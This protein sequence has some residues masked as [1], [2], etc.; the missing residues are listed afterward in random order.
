[1]FIFIFLGLCNQTCQTLFIF[2]VVIF[3]TSELVTFVAE[4]TQWKI[5]PYYQNI[6]ESVS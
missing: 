5:S 6:V 4:S 2:I 1:M 3:H